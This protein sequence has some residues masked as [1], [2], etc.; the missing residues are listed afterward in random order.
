MFQSY[1]KLLNVLK[2]ELRSYAKLRDK[3]SAAAS[4]QL[5]QDEQLLQQL[6]AAVKREQQQID[7]AL[8]RTLIQTITIGV[9][10]SIE[11]LSNQLPLSGLAFDHH[12]WKEPRLR[13]WRSEVNVG[14]KIEDRQGLRRS[15]FGHIFPTQSTLSDFILLGTMQLD[16][17]ESTVPLFYS[18][19]MCRN[20]IITT[21][22][23]GNT[24]VGDLVY[25][26]TPRFLLSA[27]P[28]GVQLLMIDPVKLG[29]KFGAFVQAFRDL[30]P[31]K[32]LIRGTYALTEERRIEEELIALEG[33]VAEITQIMTDQYRTLEELNGDSKELQEPYR[34]L[35]IRDFPHR[36]SSKAV[37]KL[38]SIMNA[39]PAC[40]VYTIIH[41]DEAEVGR[42]KI[43]DR[44]ETQQIES[45]F[46]TK[47]QIS[48]AQIVD[49]GLQLQYI[50]DQRFRVILP[51]SLRGSDA[52]LP[53]IQLLAMQ[54]KPELV[55][56]EPP[57]SVLTND[58]LNTLATLHGIGEAI[59]IPLPETVAAQRWRKDATSA[60]SIDV[61]LTGRSEIVSFELK[62]LA[63]GGV[64]VG[65][66]RSGKTNLLHVIIQ[67]ICLTYSPAEVELYLIDMKQSEFHTYG[68]DGLP[69]ARVVASKADRTFCLSVLEHLAAQQDL[70]AEAYNQAETLYRQRVSNIVEY[71][72]T[73]RTPMPRLLLIADEFQVLLNGNDALAERAR[74]LL[75]D[76]S[77]RG[78]A[79][80]IHLLL[81]TQTLREV[82]NI[83]AMLAQ[84]AIRVAMLCDEE[85]SQQI[86]ATNN[87]AAQTL[88]RQGEAILNY[89]AG[90]SE[91]NRRAQIYMQHPLP[92][93]LILELTA[94]CQ[95]RG[96]DNRRPLVFVGDRPSSP[97]E[98]PVLKEQI[99]QRNVSILNQPLRL[100]FGQDLTLANRHPLV[101]LQAVPADNLLIYGS[102]SY[103]RYVADML[104]GTLALA[105]SLM[106][107]LL[108]ITVARQSDDLD[109]PLLPEVPELTDIAT[110]VTDDIGAA[111]CR[112]ADEIFHRT[113][114]DQID[115][116]ELFT[117]VGVPRLMANPIRRPPARP[118][119]AVPAPLPVEPAGTETTPF[120]DLFIDK[121]DELYQL[122]QETR[123]LGRTMAESRVVDPLRAFQSAFDSP[124]TA[125]ETSGYDPQQL[126]SQRAKTYAELLTYILDAGPTVRVHTLIWIDNLNTFERLFE[127]NSSSAFDRRFN[128][129]LIFPIPSED[130]MRIVGDYRAVSNM[131][132]IGPTGHW[133][134]PRVYL[135]DRNTN[136]NVVLRPYGIVESRKLQRADDDEMFTSL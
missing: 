104:L 34:L 21:N 99:K 134:E 3:F 46:R 121:D 112:L 73:T 27:P 116:I 105:A 100:F 76:I 90:R 89:D 82:G 98:N 81:A 101:V 60:I 18:P 113:H 9:A 49:Q 96:L 23:S 54:E 130:A 75:S 122:L 67:Q 69:H 135:F 10:E 13:L 42:N 37:D 17:V 53:T 126:P 1:R 125:Q 30:P 129:R 70:R 111:L 84:L 79:F 118:P 15:D 74:A 92:H 136:L 114:T 103:Q 91:A 26:L 123:A 20:L 59:E 68:H 64:I 107:N 36:F 87:H 47:F 66:T 35:V 24:V 106:P 45:A 109:V 63:N 58:I 65:R 19:R 71:R 124:P 108:R 97:D 4:R 132:A 102:M 117:L 51:N 44:H 56:A 88:S 94:L 110:D 61:G 39:G 25:T 52:K 11:A 128:V 78:A 16:T 38:V 57:S 86:F 55:R 40:G 131:A 7:E 6:Q 2:G 95:D 83:G 119:V 8:Y 93:A 48:R 28:G 29:E 31:A 5:N 127:S 22:D 85:T 12:R 32:A 14:R 41:I 72:K 50:Q 77:R 115:T 33:R 133:S 43:G 80:G 62:A 120:D